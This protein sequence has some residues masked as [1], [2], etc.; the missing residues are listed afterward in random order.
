[1]RC[2]DCQETAIEAVWLTDHTARML[3][4]DCLWTSPIVDASLGSACRAQV[5]AVRS[6]HRRRVLDRWGVNIQRIEAPTRG[7]D[8]VAL[9]SAKRRSA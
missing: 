9:L 8:A 7:V 6:S 3:C 4:A 5:L 1:M 2:P